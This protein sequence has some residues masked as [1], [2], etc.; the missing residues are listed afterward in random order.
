MKSFGTLGGGNHFIEINIDEE[1]NEKYVTIHSGSRN[2]GMKLFCYHCM[3]V[4][5]I[6]KSLIGK[7]SLD[8]INDMILAQELAMMNRHIMLQLVLRAINVEF[9]INLIIESIHNYIDFNRMILRKGAISAEEG[10]QCILALNMRDGILLCTGL[11]NENWNYSCA[12]T[13][14]GTHYV[15][16]ELIHAS[17]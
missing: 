7:R 4:D 2:F 14:F 10:E 16:H 1:T 17:K 15:R 3:H 9:D 8:Y 12:P 13:P 5:P 11:G 6:H